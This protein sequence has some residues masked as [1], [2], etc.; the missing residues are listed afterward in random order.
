MT[1][2]GPEDERVSVADVAEVASAAEEAVKKFTISASKA[3]TVFTIDLAE[4]RRM[5]IQQ[6]KTPGISKYLVL[7]LSYVTSK[8]FANGLSN[9]CEGATRKL[10][11]RSQVAKV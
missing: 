4:L 10:Q 1:V 11:R 3:S 2:E 6:G 9:T 5:R 8:G 7:F